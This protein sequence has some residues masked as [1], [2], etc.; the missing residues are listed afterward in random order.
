MSS[1]EDSSDDR[2]K[3]SKL[4]VVLG[5]YA[6]GIASVMIFQWALA[7]PF[8]DSTQLVIQFPESSESQ[9]SQV[10]NITEDTSGFL[11]SFT[12]S[13][14][15]DSSC[16]QHYV[17]SRTFSEFHTGID[18][19]RSEGCKIVAPAAGVVIHAGWSESGDGY[20]VI[21][22]HGNGFQTKYAHAE[23]VYVQ[24]GESVDEG[25]KIMY[26]GCTGMCTGTHVHIEVIQNGVAINPS[27]YLMF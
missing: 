13:P 3:S 1:N 9:L 11:P 4:I 14:L 2:G 19:A 8:P 26:M 10:E 18:L 7:N 24:V 17:S 16:D 23:E 15:S 25:Q 22:D 20:S 6:L 27:D 12:V 21:L 5:A